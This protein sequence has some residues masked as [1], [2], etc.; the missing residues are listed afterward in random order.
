MAT[1]GECYWFSDRISNC[2]NR[3]ANPNAGTPWAVTWNT[4]RFNQACEHFRR[5]EVTYHTAT[6]TAESVRR[7]IK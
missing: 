1:C 3:K 7:V 5:V 6:T 4:Y 2:T